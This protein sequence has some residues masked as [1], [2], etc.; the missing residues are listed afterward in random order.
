MVLL[1]DERIFEM[2][3]QQPELVPAGEQEELHEGIM[4]LRAR[5]ILKVVCC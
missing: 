3:E 1:F 4:N 2:T 5:E